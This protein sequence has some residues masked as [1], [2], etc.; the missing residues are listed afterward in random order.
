MEFTYSDY[1]NM[2][3]EERFSMKEII[4]KVEDLE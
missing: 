3:P 2:S 1:E 4:S